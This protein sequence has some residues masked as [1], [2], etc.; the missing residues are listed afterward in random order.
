MSFADHDDGSPHRSERP[1][2]SSVTK[3]SRGGPA[4][5]GA[6]RWIA[7]SK[8]TLAAAFLAALCIWWIDWQVSDSLRRLTQQSLRSTLASSVG[9]LE[10]WLA[11][12]AR[13][14]DQ[15][16]VETEIH[17]SCLAVLDGDSDESSSGDDESSPEDPAQRLREVVR[18]SQT[19]DPCL[20]WVLLDL[21]G[22]VV[23]S[24]HDA[25]IGHRLPI[26]PDTL[27]RIEN[28][29][30]TVSRP[31]LPGSVVRSTKSALSTHANNDS[32]ETGEAIMLAL[33]PV[34]R[35]VRPVGSLGLVL[36]PM[37]RF[38]R[39]LSRVRTG[40]T[41]EV[42]AFDRRGMMISPSR[43]DDHL[44]ASGL[45]PD[46]AHMTSPLNIRLID[47]GVDLTKG[48]PLPPDWE[49]NSMTLM[50]DQATRGATGEEVTGY[51]DYR[52]VLVVGAWQWL[53]DYDFGVTAQMD[54]S[55]AFGAL[56][57]I[58]SASRWLMASLIGCAV[59]MFAVAK[60]SGRGANQS[61]EQTRGRRLGAYEL[62]ELIGSGGM[63]RVYQARHELLRRRVAV[64]VLEGANATPKSTARFRRE[65]Q[66]TSRLQH[67]NTIDIYD[68]GQDHDGTFFYVMEY[69]DGISLQ[70][71]VQNYGRQPA[72]RV[73]ML[74]VQVCHSLAEAHQAMI[75]HRDIKPANVLLTSRAGIHD[76]VK[77]VDFGLVKQ[78]DRETVQ[79]TQSDGITG[80]PHFLS[81]EAIRDA[82]AADARSDLY[83]VGAVGYYLLTGRALFESD[84]AADV[85]VKQLND[86]PARPEQVVG[87]ELPDDL[88]N[89]LMSCLR[90]S[91]EDRPQSAVELAEALGQ[92]V[93]TGDWS[94]AD[95]TR[96]WEDF[97]GPDPPRDGA[98]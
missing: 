19:T 33:S 22:A 14:A 6:G 32:A 83:S 30:S 4:A 15:I 17:R 43:F 31:L 34:C 58:R 61:H 89:V 92:C 49:N 84:S 64:K 75:I 13:E 96:W 24:D 3:A 26:P 82:S 27:Q 18:G 97:F 48:Y 11:E 41:D 74:L 65:V 56:A 71:L 47:P 9:T 12:R 1:V 88:Q 79:L 8:V 85:C 37:D 77:V 10:L 23:A 70:Q 36:N 29:L 78:I 50:A 68:V 2:S 42:Y 69:V 95:Q 57:R 52:G 55:E 7:F 91:P 44:R 86:T 98:D 72:G 66:L 60:T 94:Q 73:I 63:G 25:W 40:V 16:V 46:D 45:L 54:V 38:F 62:D 87:E 67:P 59:A 28:G 90:K 80:S 20:G 39:I 53:A 93:G 76:L 5:D 21:S 51:R 35:G 81:P